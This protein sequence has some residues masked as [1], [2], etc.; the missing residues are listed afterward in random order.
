VH[1]LAH[2]NDL[3]VGG[4]AAAVHAG[5]P[6]LRKRAAALDGVLRMI[7]VVAVIV[8]ALLRRE[9]NAHAQQQG[10]NE[11]QAGGRWCAH[12]WYLAWKV[13]RV[14]ETGTAKL[15]Y[16]PAEPWRRGMSY[17]I[18]VLLATIGATLILGAL[19]FVS[20]L[21][22]VLVNAMIVVVSGP[23][24]DRLLALRGRGVPSR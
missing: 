2:W 9:R 20:A 19:A 4:A 3:H 21:V 7:R 8:C 24:I 14:A 6:A 15:T 10:G 23:M 22:G 16:A 18:G 11:Q 12:D 13:E 17:W 1:S 5:R